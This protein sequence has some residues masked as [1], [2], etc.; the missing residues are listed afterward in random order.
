M[1]LETELKV[2]RR[3]DFTAV[4]EALLD[5]FDHMRIKELTMEKTSP[6]YQRDNSIRSQDEETPMSG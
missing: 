4:G 3:A 1:V 6:Q 5:Q 2:K